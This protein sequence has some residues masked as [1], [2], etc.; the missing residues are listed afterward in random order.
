[1]AHPTFPSRWKDSAEDKIIIRDYPR[2]ETTV[3]MF[4]GIVTRKM[5]VISARTLNQSV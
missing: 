2:D 1:M 3:Y 4:T 5:H